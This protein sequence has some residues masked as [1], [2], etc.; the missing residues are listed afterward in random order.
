MGIIEI[1]LIALLILVFL[2]IGYIIGKSAE[3]NTWEGNLDSIREDAIKRSRSVLTGSFSEQ[4]APY[5]PGFNHSP[6]EIRF[7]GKPVDFIVFEGMDQKEISKIVFVEVKSGK[8]SLSPIERNL[9]EVI[10]AGRVEWEL[11]RPPQNPDSK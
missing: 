4:L 2:M 7:I 8:S 10:K 3:R 11:Y 5:M 9:R 6:T 1:F